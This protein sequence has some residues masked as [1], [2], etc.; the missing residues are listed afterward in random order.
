MKIA[1]DLNNTQINLLKAISNREK[2]LSASATMQKYQP[3]IPRNVSKNKTTLEKKD[4]I[5]I[6]PGENRFI[7]PLFEIWLKKHS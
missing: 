3:G 1:E 6:M 4:I 7:D 5:D 2:Q